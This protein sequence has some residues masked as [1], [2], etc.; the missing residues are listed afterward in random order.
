MRNGERRQCEAASEDKLTA[1]LEKVAERLAAGAPNLERPGADLIA[2]Y[3]SP[4]R[5]SEHRSHS[6]SP[7]PGCADCCS[8]SIRG[9]ELSVLCHCLRHL[10]Q[11]L[12][13]LAQG[14]AARWR[15]RLR[16]QRLR[17]THRAPRPEPA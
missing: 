13:H 14:A 2:Y 11:R 15:E 8:R 17:G 10:G 12:H 7:V 4:G 9:H 1:R 5:L 6:N 3:L 16:L